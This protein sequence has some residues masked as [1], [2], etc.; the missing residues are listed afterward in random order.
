M[1]VCILISSHFLHAGTMNTCFATSISKHRQY[2]LLGRTGPPAESAGPS[3]A[4]LRLLRRVL[5]LLFAAVAA[6]ACPPPGVPS[7][8]ER[9]P[10][11]AEAP[12]PSAL[13]NSGAPSRRRFLPRG[14]GCGEPGRQHLSARRPAQPSPAEPPPPARASPG[15]RSPPRLPPSFP[16][17]ERDKRGEGAAADFTRPQP[18]RI[19][20]SPPHQRPRHSPPGPARLGGPCAQLPHTPRTAPRRYPGSCPGASCL[21]APPRPAPAARLGPPRATAPAAGSR[22]TWPGHLPRR[23]SSASRR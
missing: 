3:Q 13:G 19:L 18:R 14:D 4:A 15:G 2:F 9:G 8:A 12:A 17:P 5:N 21:G 6:A 7:T 11:G 23:R 1:H 22:S 16:V 20:A 10:G